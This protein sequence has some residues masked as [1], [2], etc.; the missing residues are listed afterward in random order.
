MNNLRYNLLFLTALLALLVVISYAHESYIEK[1]AFDEIARQHEVNLHEIKTDISNRLNDSLN[2][3]YFLYSTPPIS[4]LVRA[5]N[6]PE[7]IDRLDNT[8]FEGWRSRL[9]TIFTAFL[10]NNEQYSQARV[11]YADSGKEFI[12]VDK[13]RN[14]VRIIR[15][16]MLQDKSQRDYFVNAKELKREQLYI[17]PINLNREHGELS[18]PYQPTIRFILPVFS[19]DGELFA[20][21]VINKRLSSMFAS[22]EEFIPSG[23]QLVYTDSEGYFLQHFDSDLFFSRDLAP[24]KKFD[25][26]Y[27]QTELLPDKLSRVASS[28][29][30]ATL[31][32]V[33]SDT[34]IVPSSHHAYTLTLSIFSDNAFLASFLWE[35]RVTFYS[36]TGIVLLIF[37]L[38]LSMLNRSA[39]R[40]RKLAIARAES[41][42]VVTG[43][44]DAIIT[45]DK[46]GAITSCNFAAEKM[47]GYDKEQL[48]G[49]KLTEYF[50]PHSDKPI[51][52]IL[53]EQVA[54]TD[55]VWQNAQKHCHYHCS[56]STIKQSGVVSAL[57]LFFRDTTLETLAKRETENINQLLESKIAKRTKEL[58]LARNQAVES[59]KIKSQ[60]ISNI[61][62]EMRTPLNGIFGALTMLHRQTLRPETKKFV[63]MAEISASNLNVLINDI[64][65]LSKIEAG[66][67]DLDS[68]QFNP[69]ALIND[70]VTTQSVKAIE[71]GLDIYLDTSALNFRVFRSDPHRLAQ[72][73]NNILNNAI[74]FTESGSVTVEARSIIDGDT[75]T[76]VITVTDTGIGIAKEQLP[77][78]FAAF[79]QADSDITSRFGGTGLGLL[80]CKQLIQLLGGDISLESEI[81]KGTRITITL[82]SDDWETF[83][84]EELQ[85]LSGQQV[86][87]YTGN[88]RSAEILANI[89]TSLSGVPMRIPFKEPIAVNE[90]LPGS[91]I[92][93]AP[94]HD[95]LRLS[96]FFAGQSVQPK[97]F[98]LKTFTQ[99]Y[100]ID[101][102]NIQYL[103][104]PLLRN[105]FLAK[106]ID[107]RS[108]NTE[109]SSGTYHR[110]QSDQ[111]SRTTINSDDIH[112]KVLLV[113]DD[114]DINLEVASSLLSDLP[115]KIHT[116]KTGEEAIELIKSLAS[117]N[118][119]INTILMDCNM[120]GID[121]YDAT[122]LIREG[123]AGEYAKYVPIV[124]MTANALQGEK[125]K[126]LRVG[127]NDFITKPL[128]PDEF[129]HKTVSWLLADNSASLPKSNHLSSPMK[130]NNDTSTPSIIPES[131][132]P[133]AL[134]LP[135]WNKSA[136][137]GR[138][139]NN[140]AL[141]NKL[142]EMF[143]KTSDGLFNELAQAVMSHDYETVRQR[144]HKLKGQTAELGAEQ[145]YETMKMLEQ[146]AKEQSP[147]ITGL[148]ESA[149]QQ[150]DEL[151]HHL[152]D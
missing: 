115:L 68:K 55:I 134:D 151:K 102:P 110:R 49:N 7:G 107:E 88:E 29:G 90:V 139:M 24:E 149:K 137:L 3:L 31:Y 80:I 16:K 33:S 122:S 58:E 47:L 57:A 52:R 23:Q 28:T 124:A 109:L 41:Q 141:L 131:T 129:V 48:I 42:A 77:K 62:H 63:E 36:A 66:K 144:S 97:L 70:Q 104:K 14:D 5:S 120:P 51:E 44:T 56:K 73:L 136:A 76:L 20:F 96:A 105:E 37:L 87:I 127:M 1:E 101:Y 148:H 132:M 147:E 118:I 130:N 83:S 2:T 85:R 25:T 116:A 99:D 113:V 95:I 75:G 143:L 152:P 34:L 65:D 74:K 89:V 54:D 150:F 69:L 45:L 98:V 91:I 117:D 119:Q 103:N 35:R 106:F 84:K 123:G 128:A 133:D 126:C 145:L 15:G 135:V 4:G 13:V 21:L 61:S 72:V 111:H 39:A 27:E 86:G 18:I 30:Q 125:E 79:Q 43:A 94:Q 59:S 71:K 32:Y 64:L 9:E 19:E 11:I 112:G 140:E 121:G 10:K 50:N 53:S 138:L 12:R 93:D 22:A 67:L 142:I 81:D 46:H 78:L 92:L 146:K 38:A 26:V 60:F 82:S 114:N 100:T 40:S 108:D 17:T 6:D 8:S